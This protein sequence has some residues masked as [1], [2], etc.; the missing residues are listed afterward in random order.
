MIENARLNMNFR[1]SKKLDKNYTNEE[2]NTIVAEDFMDLDNDNILN[3]KEA[4]AIG[5]AA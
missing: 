3:A 5:F 2:L 4:N 1:L